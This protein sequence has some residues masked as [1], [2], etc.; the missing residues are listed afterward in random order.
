MVIFTVKVLTGPGKVYN[1]FCGGFLHLPTEISNG[2]INLITRTVTF[3]SNEER[4]PDRLK[5]L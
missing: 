2:I 3:N 5:H 4:R 1:Y